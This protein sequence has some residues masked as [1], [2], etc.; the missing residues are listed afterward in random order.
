MYTDE[1]IDFQ[2]LATHAQCLIN[3]Q[4]VSAVS[5]DSNVFSGL[6]IFSLSKRKQV[7]EFHDGRQGELEKLMHDFQA[8][9]RC[10][11]VVKQKRRRGKKGKKGG[12][13]PRHSFLSIW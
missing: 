3:E 1:C 12:R 5:A 4:Y 10:S 2:N 9:G 11:F 7:Q 6:H 13:P 8:S